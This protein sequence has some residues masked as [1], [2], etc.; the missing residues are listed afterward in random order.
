MRGSNLLLFAVLVCVAPFGSRIAFGG[1]ALRNIEVAPGGSVRLN[2]H[3]TTTRDC[4]PAALPEVRLIDPPSGGTMQVRRA[5]LTTGQVQGCPNLRVPAEVVFYVSR[6]DYTGKDHLRYEVR[7]V[8]GESRTFEF[9]IIV[10]L[11]RGA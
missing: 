7:A 5:L 1:D 8:S 11:Q 10:R 6:S 3:L 9:D 2:V 4:K